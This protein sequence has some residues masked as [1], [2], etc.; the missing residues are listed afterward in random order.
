MIDCIT[1]LILSH[2]I[3][4][5]FHCKGSTPVAAS[6]CGRPEY[7][8]DHILVKCLTRYQT[9][10]IKFFLTR[11]FFFT[12]I[13]FSLYR[14]F[15]TPTASRCGRITKS[16]S[17]LTRKSP[18]WGESISVM[19]DGT[20]P[21]IGIALLLFYWSPIWMKVKVKTFFFSIRNKSTSS[22]HRFRANS[23]WLELW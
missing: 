13:L 23:Y 10:I 14:F 5:L 17:S 9:T 18:F 15:A 19:D 20:R 16:A 7:Y 6:C 3:M 1:K 11:N 22:L 12:F 8:P 21:P 2:Y 4:F